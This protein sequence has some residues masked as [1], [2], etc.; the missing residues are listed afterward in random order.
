MSI[1]RIL[2]AGLRGGGGKTLVSLG[3]T[4]AWRKLGR[5]V[6][7]FKKGPDYIDAAWLATAAGRACR[8]LD[9]FLMPRQ[10]I[11]RSFLAASAE[12]DVAAESTA[13]PETTTPATDAATTD[14]P[15][16]TPATTAAAVPSFDGPPAPD[17]ELDL[18]DGTKFT[19]A[20]EE[21]PVFMVFWAEW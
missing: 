11:V 19:L 4:A 3:L 13:A 5:R 18:N 16:D 15:A 20:G 12:A 10:T 2:I 7:P 17:F 8:N 9:L 6:A 1:P 14:E 21:K